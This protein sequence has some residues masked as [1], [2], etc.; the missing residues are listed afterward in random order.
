MN[1]KEKIKET[2]KEKIGDIVNNLFERFIGCPSI[3]EIQ[4]YLN[5]QGLLVYNHYDS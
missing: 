2:I 5:N 1:L 4:K 3:H